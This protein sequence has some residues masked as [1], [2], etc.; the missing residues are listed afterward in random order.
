MHL[1]ARLAALIGTLGLAGLGFLAYVSY[2]GA[3]SVAIVKQ[4]DL[5]EALGKAAHVAAGE[6]LIGVEIVGREARALDGSLPKEILQRV[7]EDRPVHERWADV[8]S[9]RYVWTYRDTGAGETR[10]ALVYVSTLTTPGPFFRYMIVPLAVAAAIVVWVSVWAGL[11]LARMIRQ[12][13]HQT[14]LEAS[15]AEEA[16]NRRIRDSFMAHLSHELRTPLNA[17]VGFSQVLTSGT[18]GPLGSPKNVEYAENIHR[19]GVHL[20]RLVGNILDHSRISL[21]RESL[22]N[23]EFDIA[24]AVTEAVAILSA[25]A[26]K[27]D[28]ALTVDVVPGLPALQADRTRTMQVLLNLLSNAVK[29]TDPGGSVTVSVALNADGGLEVRVTDTGIGIS[30]QDL[31]IVQKPFGRAVSDPHLSKDGTGL[32]L[33]LSISLMKLQ[34]GGL[35]LESEIGRGT[36]A[37]V[38]F[39]PDR[40]SSLQRAS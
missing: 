20:S 8:A 13:E 2:E 40:T 27:G 4:T 17:I 38:T 28:V 30:R 25:E 10:H 11:F 7:V 3:Q 34:G 5:L 33:S 23:S 36:R 1:A 15:L 24:D 16:E 9:R 14:A 6:T 37:V 31:E 21:G 29:F 22:H 12:V 19:S 18:F 39:P 26:E 35:T 32:G